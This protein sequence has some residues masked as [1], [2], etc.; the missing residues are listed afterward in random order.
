MIAD[1][2]VCGDCLE[3]LAGEIFGM[4]RSEPESDIRESLSSVLK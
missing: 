2:V 1:V 4:R 3:Q